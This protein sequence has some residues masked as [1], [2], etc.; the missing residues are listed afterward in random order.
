MAQDVTHRNGIG[1]LTALTF[2]LIYGF[3]GIV[4]WTEEPELFYVVFGYFA[5]AWLIAWILLNR[6]R[7]LLS[8]NAQKFRRWFPFL[9]YG[10]EFGDFEHIFFHQSD[11]S[12]D[13]VSHLNHIFGST[14]GGAGLEPVDLVDCDRSLRGNETRTFQIAEITTTLRGTRVS[15]AL[16]SEAWGQLQAVRWWLILGGYEDRAKMFRFIALA[17]VTIPF[18]LVPYMFGRVNIIDRVRTIYGSAYNDMD[19]LTLVRGGHQT[20]FDA[21]VEVLEKNGI[22][23]SDLKAQRAQVMNI[24]ISG[25]KVKMGNIVQGAKN[26]ITGGVKAA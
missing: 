14:L 21:L 2:F 20:V 7:R 16:R 3:I 26:T 17:P 8:G 22:D 10:R 18:L 1:L 12:R 13:V 5:A 25:G 11:L 9:A 23:T 15:L 4:L 6:E 24:S 19:I